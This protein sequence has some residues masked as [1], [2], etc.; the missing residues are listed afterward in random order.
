MK[1]LSKFGMC[2]AWLIIKL[3]GISKMTRGQ[4]NKVL[5]IEWAIR[6][7][8]PEKEVATTKWQTEVKEDFGTGNQ[9]KILVQT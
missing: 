3:P 2:R 1:E 5:G 6:H 4:V 8:F 9:K 7:I